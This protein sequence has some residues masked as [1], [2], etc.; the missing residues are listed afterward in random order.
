MDVVT[1]DRHSVKPWFDG[2]VD[3]APPVVDLT[4]Q[5]FMLFGGR[6]DYFDG[7]LVASVVYQ[8]RNHVINLFVAQ[9]LGSEHTART[10]QGYNVRHWEA[11]LS[12]ETA[13]RVLGK[14]RL[15]LR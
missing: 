13:P 11:K 14:A 4:A 3:V 12:A 8:R 9:R 1:S 7:E 2:K 6:L 10:V 5:G 15:F